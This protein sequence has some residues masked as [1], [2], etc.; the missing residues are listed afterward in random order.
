MKYKLGS[1]MLST[2]GEF[3]TDEEAIK[4]LAD[5]YMTA[6]RSDPPG[7]HP[8]EIL[9]GNGPTRKVEEIGKAVWLYVYTANQFGHEE[10]LVKHQLTIH[11]FKRDHWEKG[12]ELDE[13]EYSSEFRY[14][15]HK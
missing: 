5:R 3:E 6:S 11:P 4:T 1:W 13:S 2:E 12:H 8:L 15:I 9:A 14:T 10:W 7:R